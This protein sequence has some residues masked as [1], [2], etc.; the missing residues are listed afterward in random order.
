MAD[1]DFVVK[2]GLVVG[3]NNTTFGTAVSLVSNGNVGIGNSTP[4]TKLHI[5]RAPGASFGGEIW[6]SEGAY[7]IQLNSR[8]SAGAYSPLVAAGD[9][10][11]IYSDGT[12]E[13]GSLVIGQWSSSARGIRIDASGNVGIG[14]A[15]PAEK[16]DVTGSITATANV[17]AASI[18]ASTGFYGTVQTA[19]QATI[20]HN[21]LANYVADR[22]IAHSAVSITAGTGLS[23]GGTID[24]S[25]T[26]NVTNVPNSVTFNNGGVG[27]V[28]GTTFN[29]SSAVTI[30]YNS[31]G[32]PSTTGTNASGTWS[33][34]INGSAASA[35]NAS[36]ATN[37]NFATSAGSAT[38]ASFATS[39]GS[40]TNAS[41]ATSAGSTSQA[42][43]FASDGT[44]AAATTTFNGGTARVISYNS[45]GAPS[46]TGTNASGT[47]SIN[48]N[49][50]SGSTATATTATN[51]SGGT[52]SATTGSFSSDLSFN[53][54]YGSAAVAYGCRSWIRF[55]TSLGT[56]S[57]TG[58]GNVSTITDNGTG[59]FTIN[60]TTALVDANYGAVANYTETNSATGASNDGQASCHTHA[61]GSVRV[62]C[63]RGDGSATD[64][65]RCT[66]VVY[67]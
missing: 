52:V 30:S 57:I 36:A 35:T 14:T 32:A 7:W 58:D 27:A 29:G 17:S 12:S 60:F 19:T 25:R 37:A 5:Q 54:G 48:I 47:W 9:H 59:A 16:L 6:S 8:Q 44:G 24:A 50:S 18:N 56:P 11:L 40:A 31:I 63:A 13:T 53:S 10:A 55:A 51:V 39:A 22:H 62:F 61:T 67:R 38:N 23:G 2:N 20:D 64:P 4:T 49:G 3:A 33:I 42:L 46:I 66:V 1:K 65:A 34:N 28:S 15:S 45:V 43:T 41:F 26:L 21:T